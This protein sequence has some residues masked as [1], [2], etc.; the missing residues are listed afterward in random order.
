MLLGRLPYAVLH[1]IRIGYNQTGPFR[2]QIIHQ[3]GQ[4]Q[5]GSVGGV[6]F[7]K[8]EHFDPW[9]LAFNIEPGIVVSLAPAPIVEGA[10]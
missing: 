5:S 6:Y 8:I 7:I 2:N 9:Q 4:R 10:D 3:L 1:V